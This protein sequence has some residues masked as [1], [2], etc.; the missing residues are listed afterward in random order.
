MKIFKDNDNIGYVDGKCMNYVSTLNNFIIKI[1]ESRYRN[2]YVFLFTFL[3][4]LFFINL[5]NGNLFMSN[6]F[7]TFCAQDIKNLGIVLLEDIDCQNNV[8]LNAEENANNFQVV[9]ANE[10]KEINYW[11]QKVN[12]IGYEVSRKIVTTGII[13]ISIIGISIIYWYLING[14]GNIIIGDK[15]EQI[16]NVS[17]NI[18]IIEEDKLSSINSNS[19]K[20]VQ[21][22]ISWERSED[23][24]EFYYYQGKN[25]YSVMT[26]EHKA[27]YRMHH[28]YDDYWK[29][30][31]CKK[32]EN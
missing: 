25:Y 7:V 13:V 31:N 14:A 4:N 27:A 26:E 19:I 16:V 17:N 11:E 28:E 5:F 9:N 6:I 3:N 22:N 12:V 29:N 32:H 24:Y 10:G 1:W 30:N 21:Q 20:N 2:Y 18:D 23:D 8:S 15:E